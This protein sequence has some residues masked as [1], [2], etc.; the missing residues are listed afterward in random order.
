MP[1]LEKAEPLFDFM[2]Y[3]RGLFRFLAGPRRF[4]TSLDLSSRAELKRS[5]EYLFVGFTGAT[6]LSALNLHYG[7]EGWAHLEN[8]VS[9]DAIRIGLLLG[10]LC[11]ALLSH[12]GALALGGRGGAKP[13]FTAFALTLGFV[14]PPSALAMIVIGRLASAVLG[15]DWTLAGPVVTSI[16]G[17]ILETPAAIGWSAFLFASMLWLLL[18]NLYCYAG[19]IAVSHGI[20]LWRASAAVAVAAVATDFLN[21]ALIWCANLL[22]AVFGPVLEWVFKLF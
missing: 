15:V 10:G 9:G 8:R 1:E 4:L 22:E 17:D 12:I 6:A 3:P 14:W 11:A 13:T 20:G 21:P 19:A 18:F 7:P 16:R 2:A 5:I